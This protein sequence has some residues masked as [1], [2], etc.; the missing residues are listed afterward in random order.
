MNHYKNYGTEDF[1]W[2]TFFRQWVLVPTRETDNKWKEWLSENPEMSDKISQARQAVLS[3]NVKEPEISNL[4][5]AEIVKE[6]IA[7]AKPTLWDTE[8]NAEFEIIP[9]YKRFWF[10]IAASLTLFILFGWLA[11]SSLGLKN[12]IALTPK[13]IVTE[14]IVRY[15]EKINATSSPIL[16][17]LEDGSK[18]TL[19]PSS[20]IRY[21]EN[22]ANEKREVYLNGEAFFDISK[23]PHRPFFVYSNELVTKVLGTS[24]RIKA[25]KTSR[26][27]TVEVKTGRVSV[28]AQSDPNIKEKITNHE[29]E[30]VVLSPNQKIIYARD[31]VRM[32]KTLVEK[33]EIIIP[34][35]QIPQFI[36]E[37]APV[38]QVF[39]SIAKTYG[40]D[41]LYDEEMLKGCPLTAILDNQTLHEK[42]TIICKAIEANYEILD[43][44]I[45]IHGGGCKN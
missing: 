10:K 7:R 45:V 6:T 14:D 37:D 30:G 15:T 28:F 5:I 31:Q 1:V 11:K 39:D 2:D 12:Q 21:P 26:E 33:P 16:V 17:A 40:I 23:D 19:A 43:G 35:A 36:F 27:I 3:L 41:I 8:R 42:L 38:T 22:F 25:Y 34:K 24:F 13:E 20:I 9:F 32:V 18:I 44:Q 29:L 4:E